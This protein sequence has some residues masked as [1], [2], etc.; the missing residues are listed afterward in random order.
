MISVP[1]ESPRIIFEAGVI[2]ITDRGYLDFERLYALDQAGGFFV[3]R[4]KRNLDARRLY[5][6]LVERGQRPD[7]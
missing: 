1:D 2:Y 4:A 5:S 3:T 6:A 7:L